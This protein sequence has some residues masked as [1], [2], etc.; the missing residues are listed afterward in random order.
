MEMEQ[1]DATP[2]WRGRGG[3]GEGKRGDEGGAQERLLHITLW[4]CEERVLI[5]FPPKDA[6]MSQPD[7]A[8]LARPGLAR[9]LAILPPVEG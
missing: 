7:P 8:D 1:E 5:L 3:R 9:S 6:D 2:A 4:S